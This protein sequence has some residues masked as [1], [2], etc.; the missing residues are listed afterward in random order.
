MGR[1]FSNMNEERLRRCCTL[2]TI[3]TLKG[4]EASASL[5]SN[6]SLLS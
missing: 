3:V 1:M 6:Q 2:Q 5:H 4:D